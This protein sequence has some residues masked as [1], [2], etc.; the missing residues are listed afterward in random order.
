MLY[1]IKYG[2]LHQYK[3]KVKKNSPSAVILIF[4]GFEM[5][6]SA[7]GHKLVYDIRS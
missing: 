5:S 1:T 2:F 7:T 3:Q 6:H 4:Y